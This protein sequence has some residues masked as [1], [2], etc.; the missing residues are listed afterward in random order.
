MIGIIARMIQPAF[1]YAKIRSM[2][3]WRFGISTEFTNQDL[4]G[5]SPGPSSYEAVDGQQILAKELKE[6][7]TV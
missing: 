2:F 3:N 4:L 5:I 6:F 7:A 1:E